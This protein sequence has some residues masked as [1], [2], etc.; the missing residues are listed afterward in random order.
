V[1]A[2]VVGG[3]L[4]PTCA[5]A[6]DL[7]TQTAPVTVVP[8][9]G[10]PPQVTDNRSNNNVHVTMYRK[11]LYRSSGPPSGTSRATT[12]CSTS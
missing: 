12:Q 10:L 8:S 7:S 3:L 4:A 5:H 11:R 2:A 1:L 6:A 9:P